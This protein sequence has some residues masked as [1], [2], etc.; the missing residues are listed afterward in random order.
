MSSGRRTGR[1]QAVGTVRPPASPPAQVPH[2][3][4][5]K[6][7]Q[8]VNSSSSRLLPTPARPPRSRPCLAA[9]HRLA[10]R[11]LHHQQ[12]RLA[13]TMRVSSPRRPAAH[14]PRRGLA[15]STSTTAPAH[16]PFHL[17]RR[18]RLDVKHPRTWVGGVADQ[19]PPAG[20][21]LLISAARSTAS[22]HGVYPPAARAHPT[23]SPHRPS[24]TTTCRVCAHP[25]AETRIPAPFPA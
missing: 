23:G 2:L 18:L 12:I 10:V 20:A 4:G 16:F 24:P 22:T 17:E 11:L 25:H 13:A 14:P 1:A 6:S 15:R 19:D 7:T 21:F 3:L 9:V 5:S 8:A